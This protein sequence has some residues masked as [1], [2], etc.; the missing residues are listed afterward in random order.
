MTLAPSGHGS[1]AAHVPR[2][3][4]AAASVAAVGGDLDALVAAAV[5]GDR[6]ALQGLL[7]TI[8]VLTLRYCRARIREQH[9]AAD[10]VAQE[11]CIAILRALPGT[12]TK[13]ARSRHS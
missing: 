3:A 10:D 6:M 12:G 4:Q 7:R 1:A 2:A 13:G 5:D 8:H 9:P 11:V